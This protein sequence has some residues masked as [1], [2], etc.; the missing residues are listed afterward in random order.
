MINKKTM[1]GVIVFLI[2]SSLFLSGC[3]LQDFGVELSRFLDGV[4][5]ELSDFWNR[6]G[7][8]FP[9]IGSVLE[10]IMAGLSGVGDAIKDM[11]ANFSIF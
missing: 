5:S 6:I 7:Q 11:F 4:A 1:L 3:S 10:G 2:L 9:D 8:N